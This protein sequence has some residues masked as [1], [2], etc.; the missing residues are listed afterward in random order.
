MNGSWQRSTVASINEEAKHFR[1]VEEISV[2]E[3][4]TLLGVDN[5]TLGKFLSKSNKNYRPPMAHFQ[6]QQAL[7]YSIIHETSMP[8]GD[9]RDRFFPNLRRAGDRFECPLPL[10]PEFWITYSEHVKDFLTGALTFMSAVE[11]VMQG[12]PRADAKLWQSLIE[13]IGTSLSLASTIPFRNS[14][15]AL[16]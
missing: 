6:L 5:P 14:G 9:I 4:L 2:E 10:T 13:P 7:G 8:I 3:A 12:H 15:F 11:P 16:L 1:S